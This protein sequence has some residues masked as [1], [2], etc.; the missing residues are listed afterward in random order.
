ME[1]KK[2]NQ[3]ET[4]KIMVKNHGARPYIKKSWGHALHLTHALQHHIAS[5]T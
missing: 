4:K 2:D 3:R 5:L 1:N